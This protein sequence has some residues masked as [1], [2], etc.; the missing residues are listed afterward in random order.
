VQENG[1]RRG[2]VGIPTL[3]RHAG[4]PFTAS[5]FCCVMASAKKGQQRLNG[6]MK[7]R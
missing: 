1:H 4:W 2:T 3:R 6:Y 7:N 5:R